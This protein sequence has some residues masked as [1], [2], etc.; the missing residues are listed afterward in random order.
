MKGIIMNIKKLIATT[1]L[2]VA[3]TGCTTLTNLTLEESAALQAKQRAGK[4]DY[5]SFDQLKKD[6]EVGTQDPQ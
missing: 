3:L 2:A 4:V 1:I 5:V 6:L